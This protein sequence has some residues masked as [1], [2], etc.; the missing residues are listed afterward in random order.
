M[1]AR[2]LAEISPEIG[3]LSDREYRTAF[4]S[5]QINIG[6]PFQ[7]RALM[8]ARGWKQ[9]D[10]AARANMLQPQISRIMTPGRTRPN[11]ETL[12]RLAKAF[13]CGLLVRFVPFGDLVRWSEEFNPE[14]FDVVSFKDDPAFKADSKA[15]R[16][17]IAAQL[18]KC[19]EIIEAEPE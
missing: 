18:R 17:K 1:K 12:R 13:D 3:K 19:L 8:K 9:D 2:K 14:S 10:L 16:R 5:S 11:I 7:I 6:I 4:V 15:S